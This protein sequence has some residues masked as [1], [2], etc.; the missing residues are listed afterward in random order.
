[1]SNNL[2][3]TD[4]VT[5][6]CSSSYVTLKKLLRTR[7]L[8]D[9]DTKKVLAQALIVSKLDYCNSLLL[10]APLKDLQRL[11]STQKHVCPLRV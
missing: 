6:V 2:A 1:M 4:H 10:G 3:V 11:Q 8:I 9:K 7:H 5:K